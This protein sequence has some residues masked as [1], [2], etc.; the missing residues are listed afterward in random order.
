MRI[1]IT[2]ALGQL[3]RD[4]VK[5]AI[6]RGFTALALPRD[7]LDITDARRTL[8]AIAD[9]APG[10]VINCAAYTAVDRAEEEQQLAFAVNRDGASNLA[11]ACGQNNVPLIHVSTDYVCDGT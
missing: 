3:G 8:K 6:N 2:G 5:A 10:M 9:N 1:L 7:K 4:V 11:A